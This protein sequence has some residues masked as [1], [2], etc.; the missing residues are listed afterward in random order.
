MSRRVVVM[1]GTRGIGAAI[2]ARFLAAGDHVDAVGRAQ[3]DVT[4]EA[5]VGALFDRAGAIDVLVNSAGI[6]RSA[7]LKRTTLA[8]WQAQ[9]EVNATGAFLCT[10]AALPGMLE[11]G[12]GRI[13]TVASTAGVA[14]RSTPR[15]T[16]PPSTLP[17]GSRARSP[18]RSPAPG[19]PPTACARRS[20]AQT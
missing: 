5:A 8:D 18:P 15:P 14:G 16:R 7:P 2:V 12:S 19:S 4:D 20:C 17:S 3:C 13:V 1:G 6:S 11:R 10:R 9:V